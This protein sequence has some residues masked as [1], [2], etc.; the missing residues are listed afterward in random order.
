MLGGAVDPRRKTVE[1]PRVRGTV[2]PPLRCPL[3]TTALQHL[4]GDQK[5]VVPHHRWKLYSSYGKPFPHSWN[6]LGHLLVVVEG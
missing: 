4:S 2:E 3:P 5:V 6:S 1:I